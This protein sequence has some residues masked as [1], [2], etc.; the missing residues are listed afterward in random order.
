MPYAQSRAMQTKAAFDW[1]EGN[2]DF[3]FLFEHDQIVAM[4]RRLFHHDSEWMA[5]RRR[6]QSIASVITIPRSRNGG[7]V[8]SRQTEREPLSRPP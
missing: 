8:S 7:A 5:C 1:V 3:A 4:H 6:A 2:V